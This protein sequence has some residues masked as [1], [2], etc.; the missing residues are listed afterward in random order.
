MFLMQVDYF[1]LVIWIV[2]AKPKQSGHLWFRKRSTFSRVRL[3][4]VTHENRAPPGF[5]LH[6]CDAVRPKSMYFYFYLIFY[7]TIVESSKQFKGTK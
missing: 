3:K 1:N 5:L 7:Q 2:A 4:T 6:L